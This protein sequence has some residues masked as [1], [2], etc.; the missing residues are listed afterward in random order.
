MELGSEEN[1][2]LRAKRFYEQKARPLQR[3]YRHGNADRPHDAALWLQTMILH[4]AGDADAQAEPGQRRRER[5]TAKLAS[6]R[7]RAAREPDPGPR[8]NIVRSD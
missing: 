8:R 4:A 5:S 6:V 1:P 7:R 2:A 3:I